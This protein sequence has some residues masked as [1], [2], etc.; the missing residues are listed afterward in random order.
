VPSAADGKTLYNWDPMLV[1]RDE[2]GQA[3]RLAEARYSENG[4]F[5]QPGYYSQGSIR[6]STDEAQ[7][8]SPEIEVPEWRGANEIALLRAANGDIVAACRTD[9]PKEFA[10]EYDHYG[11]L[12]I[13]I[14]RDDGCT[15]SAMDALYHWGRHHPSPVLMPNGDIVL[16]YVVR[17]GYPDTADGYPRAGI[18]AVVSRGHG[19]TWDLDHK[20]ILASWAGQIKDSWW[21]SSQSTSTVLLPDGALLTAFGTGVRNVPGQTICKM[22][23]ALVRWELSDQPVSVETTIRSAPYDSATRNLFDL[24]AV[25]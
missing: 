25:R 6:F 2:N 19:R 12:G 1:D 21:G 24:D 8:W 23:V 22:D 17:K 9:L 14:S 5:G 13:S 18:E 11:G 15:W 4:A 3:V 20:Y 16:T 10:A 7:T